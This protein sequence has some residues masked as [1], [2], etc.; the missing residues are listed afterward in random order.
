M[1]INGAVN[2]WLFLCP[3]PKVDLVNILS[4]E[5]D[6]LYRPT[7]FFSQKYT[8]FKTEGCSPLQAVSFWLHTYAALVIIDMSLGA[9]VKS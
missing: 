4:Q 1:S 9:S 2:V 5:E 7:F 8:Y 3:S 6:N